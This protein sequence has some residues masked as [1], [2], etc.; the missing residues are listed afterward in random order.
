MLN[1]KTMTN[2][3]PP[4]K[5]NTIIGYIGERCAINYLENFGFKVHISKGKFDNFPYFR[6]DLQILKFLY[7]KVKKIK[8]KKAYDFETGKF[9]GDYEITYYGDMFA[10]KQVEVK[11]SMGKFPKLLKSLTEAQKKRE[12]KPYFLRIKI[13]QFSKAGVF[14]DVKENPENWASGDN[15]NSWKNQVHPFHPTPEQMISYIEK[16]YIKK[17]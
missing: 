15:L 13:I 4:K 6:G 14:F 12:I 10:K 11:A 3:L 9:S 7:P 8:P 17:K 5:M 1:L 16:N 2:I